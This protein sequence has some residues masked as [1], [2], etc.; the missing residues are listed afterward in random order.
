M[1]T[2]DIAHVE[3]II[4]AGAAEQIMPRC[5]KLA[6]HDVEMKGVNDPVT[7]AD[8]ESERHLTM[9]LQ[10]YLPGSVVVGEESFAKDP[11]ILAHIDGSHPVWIIDPIDGTRNFVS[12]VPELWLKKAQGFGCVVRS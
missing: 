2:V 4:R 10:D 11:S 1:K 3:N 6:E 12:G 9:Q 5:R 8:K 7:V